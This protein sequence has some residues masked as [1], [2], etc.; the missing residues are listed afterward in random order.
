MINGLEKSIMLF[1]KPIG[2][3]SEQEAEADPGG[4]GW[5]RWWRRLV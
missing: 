1:S 2:W 5:M 3:G 4:G